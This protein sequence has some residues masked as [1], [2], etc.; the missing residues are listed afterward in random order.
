MSSATLQAND[1]SSTTSEHKN[2]NAVP[3]AIYSKSFRW[4]KADTLSAVVSLYSFW[5]NIEIEFTDICTM[6]V[7]THI[8]S[9]PN[10]AK[11]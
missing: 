4:E 10:Y 9:F 5:L 6:V 2:R 8:L 7:L 3:P 11:R 1:D